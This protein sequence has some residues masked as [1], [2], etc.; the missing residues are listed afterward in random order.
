MAIQW[1]FRMNELVF[2]EKDGEWYEAKI[3]GMQGSWDNI[4]QKIIESY[5]VEYCNPTMGPFELVIVDRIK[6][7]ND[8]FIV[9]LIEKGEITP[10]V[11]DLSTQA[12]IDEMV[13]AHNKWRAEVGVPP[14]TWDAELARHAQEWANNLLE[15]DVLQHSTH[16]QR[17]YAGEN[18]FWSSDPHVT[19][20]QVVDAWGS[21]KQDNTKEDNSGWPDKGCGP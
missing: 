15:L 19:P 2:V 10:N 20:T 7:T 3:R 12:G 4:Q 1:T 17:D 14:V 9:D 16:S 21:E 8:P 18:L 6:N 5:T 13:A 11:Y